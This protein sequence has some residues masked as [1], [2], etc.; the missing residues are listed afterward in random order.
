MASS[1]PQQA[2]ADRLGISLRT[3]AVEVAALKDLYD[4]S[5]LPEL[6][7]KW[8]LSPDRLVDDSAP[9]ALREPRRAAAA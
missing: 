9:E 6:V 2:T 3:L 5:S 1:R 8:A 4:A 7:Y